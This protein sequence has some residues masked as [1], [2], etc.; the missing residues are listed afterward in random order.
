MALNIQNSLLEF[1]Y[2]KILIFSVVGFI[3][4]GIW[5]ALLFGKRYLKELKI[6]PKAMEESERY[7][8]KWVRLMKIVII[9]LIKVMIFA[10]L[11]KQLKL[12]SLCQRYKLAAVL[13][14]GFSLP[15]YVSPSLWEMKSW[16]YFSINFGCQV[17]FYV[18]LASFWNYI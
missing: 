18:V 8:N 15:T 7:V 5:Y 6:D 16:T 9:S 2:T 17:A 4:G 13:I 10:Y 3:V 12:E 1:D 11:V 14:F